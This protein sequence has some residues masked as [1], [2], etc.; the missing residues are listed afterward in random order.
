MQAPECTFCDAVLSPAVMLWAPVEGDLKDGE[1]VTWYGP[2]CP[3]CGPDETRGICDTMES[4]GQATPS[5]D[6]LRDWVDVHGCKNEDFVLAVADRAD[7]PRRYTSVPYCGVVLELPDWFDLPDTDP[8]IVL[9]VAMEWW[10]DE[11]LDW[12]RELGPVQEDGTRA[13]WLVT[14][15]DETKEQDR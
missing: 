5:D 11:K 8:A 4:E 10:E 1:W 6:D 13:V 12:S 14:A 9:A 15:N 7:V 2:V 3:S